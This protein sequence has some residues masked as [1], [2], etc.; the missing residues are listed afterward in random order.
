M[1]AEQTDNAEDDAFPY[2]MH[3][4]REWV[5][6]VRQQFDQMK[7]EVSNAY[8]TAQAANMLANTHEEA[9]SKLWRAHDENATPSHEQTPKS[10]QLPDSN[11]FWRDNEGEIWAYDGDPD[12]PPRFIFSTTFQEVCETPADSTANWAFIEDYAPFTKISNPFTTGKN[13]ADR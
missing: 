13:H 7:D 5:N 12:N 6:S 8:A 3:T 1:E 2:D 9:I 4:F 10:P 11:G